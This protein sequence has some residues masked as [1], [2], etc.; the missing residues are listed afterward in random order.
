MSRR[1]AADSVI[2]AADT[3]ALYLELQL[4]QGIWEAQAEERRRNDFWTGVGY[5]L[6]GLMMM[7]A[8]RRRRRR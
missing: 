5:V 6:G 2:A 4:K 7:W 3:Y 8:S 1:S